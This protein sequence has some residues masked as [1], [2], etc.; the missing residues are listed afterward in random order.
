VRRPFGIAL[1]LASLAPPLA[2]QRARLEVSVPVA[3]QPAVVRAVDVLADKDMRN[4]LVNGFPARLHFRGEL[5]SVSGWFNDLE[6]TVEW[7]LVVQ[8]DAFS[9]SYR[10]L[11][12]L[13]D[14]LTPLGTFAD[15]NS[16]SAAMASPFRLP[17][18]PPARRGGRYYYSASLDLET[19]SMSDLDELERWLRGELKPAVRG[20]KN[21]GTAITR[22]LRTLFVRLLGG[23]KRHY[24]AQSGTFRT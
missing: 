1:I 15:L 6:G 12:I 18:T 5:W 20:Q 2:A 3:G 13:G 19:L 14:Q 4:L 17:L 16:A 24:E 8:F 22:G 10:V 23:E 11:R 9:K 21:P 7:D